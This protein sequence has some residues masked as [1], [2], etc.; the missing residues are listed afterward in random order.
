MHKY[1]HKSLL[2]IPCAEIW[3]TMF[4]VTHQPIRSPSNPMCKNSPLHPSP[5][6]IMNPPHGAAPRPGT[7]PLWVCGEIQ[8]DA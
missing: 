5:R 4:P 6:A 7:D 8:S 2:F 3:L 1:Q